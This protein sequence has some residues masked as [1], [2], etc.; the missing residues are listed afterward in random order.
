MRIEDERRPRGEALHILDNLN[1]GQPFRV[2]RGTAV[3]LRLHGST[4]GDFVEWDK[5]FEFQAI[6]EHGG[7]VK[8]NR[9]KKPIIS[10]ANGHLPVI[11]LETGRLFS[12]PSGKEVIPVYA[13]AVV[14]T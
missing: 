10:V 9:V 5:R 8:W 12:F 4:T 1:A 7:T 3:Y 6:R 2:E 13:D 14:K 11:S